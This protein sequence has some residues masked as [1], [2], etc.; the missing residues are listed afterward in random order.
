[1]TTI[2]PNG[3]KAN[4]GF[5]LGSSQPIDS[6]Q[7]LTSAQMLAAD[8]NVFPDPYFAINKEDHFLYIY[9]KSNDPSVTTGYFKKYTSDGGY[10]QWTGSQADY[11]ALPEAT[12]DDNS[13]MFFIYDVSGGEN[14]YVV[15][16]Q[17]ITS[18]YS[19]TESEYQDLETKSAS[20]M[21]ATETGIR[22]GTNYVA[23]NS[24]T[25]ETDISS[26]IVCETGFSINS[27]KFYK[28]DRLCHFDIAIST[29]AVSS[30]G[31]VCTLPSTVPSMST[32][33]LPVMHTSEN[34]TVNMVKVDGRTL[35]FYPLTA[36]VAIGTIRFCY[37][38]FEEV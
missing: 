13:I 35:T 26:S 34:D 36:S 38:Y 7:W 6:R 21:Y 12:K 5:E 30:A 29:P 9:S 15:S 37:T 18:V 8:E 20:S 31:L 22:V 16:D 14:N 17:S 27:A 25:V 23:T 33:F 1:M 19:M 3:I 4:A 24:T 10:T 28:L 2:N 11:D 32:N